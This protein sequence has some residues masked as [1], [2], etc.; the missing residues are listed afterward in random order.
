M[1]CHHSHKCPKCECEFE[2]E[3]CFKFSHKCCD[4]HHK[5]CHLECG[6]CGHKF[7]HHECCDFI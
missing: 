3:C 4:C 1:S 6:K 5:E 7:C 2:H